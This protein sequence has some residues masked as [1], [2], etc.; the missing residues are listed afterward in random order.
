MPPLS[1]LQKDE[2][3]RRAA[4]EYR[5]VYPQDDFA[6]PV[7]LDFQTVVAL[8]PQLQLALRHPANQGPSS[9]LTRHIVDTLITRVQIMA[10]PAI[11]ALLRLG[12]NPDYD[13]PR[14]PAEVLSPPQLHDLELIAWLRASAPQTMAIWERNFL[15][16][17]PA[18]PEPPPCPKCNRTGYIIDRAT[19]A[20]EYC[21]CQMGRDLARTESPSRRKA[22]E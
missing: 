1:T 9:Q 21:D 17:Q 13:E 19:E 6:L 8:I 12:D 15:Q 7:I 10:L 14:I 11:A 16:S 2:L 3:M 18:P 22:A 5:D 20:T 4:D